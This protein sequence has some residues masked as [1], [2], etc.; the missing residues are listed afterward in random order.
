MSSTEH[1]WPR[2]DRATYPTRWVQWYSWRQ[3]VFFTPKVRLRSAIVTLRIWPRLGW[4]FGLVAW[5][6]DDEELT[7]RAG[8]GVAEIEAVVM[9][10]TR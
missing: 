9:Q 4:V 8:V 1:R 7:V 10:W 2:A 3:I 6:D 5:R